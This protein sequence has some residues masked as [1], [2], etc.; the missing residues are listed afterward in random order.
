[1]RVF[2]TLVTFIALGV[3]T[4]SRPRS[5]AQPPR[6]DA[7]RLRL[8]TDTLIV[9]EIAGDKETPGGVAISTLRAVPP[10]QLEMTYRWRPRA[11]DSAV[12]L[13]QLDRSSLQPL[14][15]ERR[16]P[17]GRVVRLAYGPWGVRGDT[18]EPGGRQREHA[19]DST[20]RGAYTST[21]IDL[22]L[23]A[24]PL[25]NGYRTELPV[26]FPAGIGRWSLPVRV[27]ATETIRTRLGANVECWLVEA[28]FPGPATE[29]F[30]IAKQNRDLIR[31][32]G[33][34]GPNV[35]QRYDR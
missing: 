27:V 20:A 16:Y 19:T 32:L 28:D 30:W 26:H 15:E 23:R 11:G 29:R 12:I 24:L 8:I 33:H 34:I 2:R 10:D 4:C 9:T 7:G 6:L 22:V 14:A 13:A 5:V 17:H 18:V 31:V 3:I 25:A 1:M 21:T 35:L